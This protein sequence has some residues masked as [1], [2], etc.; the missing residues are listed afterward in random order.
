MAPFS[1]TKWALALLL[2]VLFPHASA[3][4]GA[5][6]TAGLVYGY[7]RKNIPAGGGVSSGQQITGTNV[8]AGVASSYGDS[9]GSLH[10]NPRLTSMGV[11][12]PLVQTSMRGGSGPLAGLSELQAAE[13]AAAVAGQP[14]VNGASPSTS[15]GASSTTLVIALSTVGAAVGAILLTS[16]IVV[17]RRSVKSGGGPFIPGLGSLRRLRPSRA[18]TTTTSAAGKKEKSA[19]AAAYERMRMAP[20]SAAP[21]GPGSS[22]EVEFTENSGSPAHPSH[23]KDAP[24]LSDDEGEEQLS[25]D[26]DEG[27]GDVG[28]GVAYPLRKAVTQRGVPP[29]QKVRRR[30]L[31]A[32]PEVAVPTP[33]GVKRA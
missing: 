23:L 9:S 20:G 21:G 32:M 27:A 28:G 16:L 6:N 25:D 5:G 30:S 15:S 33:T 19:L 4:S 8:Y 24:E 7:T 10:V 26:E 11:L 12:S 18:T 17:R 29:T 31:N 13:F 14:N 1:Q 2:I 3:Q 22:S